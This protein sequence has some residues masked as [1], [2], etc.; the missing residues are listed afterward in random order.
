MLDDGIIDPRDTRNVLGFALTICKD[1]DARNLRPVQFGV[2]R[3]LRR[4][5]MQFTQEHE[6]I[7]RTM[8][9]FIDAEINPHVDEWEEAEQFPA[10]EV[11]KKLGDLG[12]LGLT[13]PEAYGGAALDYCYSMVFAEELGQIRCGGVPMAIG[14]QTDMATPALARFGSDELRKEFLAP[15]IAGDDVACIGVSE[16]G[17]APTSPRS[18]PTRRRTA[19]TT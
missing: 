2:A 6:E 9:R 10:H 7:R 15:A 3:P 17:A 14:V 4:Q 12:M 11:F 8:K 5:C 19:A 18:R 16:P 13:K 1:A